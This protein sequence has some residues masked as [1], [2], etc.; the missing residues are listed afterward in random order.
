MLQLV[1]KAV[2]AK[3][4]VPFHLHFH[5]HQEHTKPLTPHA[6]SCVNVII[7]YS[8]TREEGTVVDPARADDGVRGEAAADNEGVDPPLPAPRLAAELLRSI[9]SMNDCYL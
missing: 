4:S 2:H 7:K 8:P 5:D 9:R 6:T 3:V 1:L